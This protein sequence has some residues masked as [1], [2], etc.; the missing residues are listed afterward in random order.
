MKYRKLLAMCLLPLAFVAC[1]DDDAS[2][3][4]GEATI[5]FS[6]ATLEIKESIASINL[7]IVVTGTHD[8]LIKLSA[9]MTDSNGSNL[10]I[11]K[12]VIITTETLNMPV[13]TETVNL[14]VRLEGVTNDEIENGR[15]IVFEITNVEGATLGANA[16]CTV[17][18]VENNPLE[19]IY[20][21]GGVDA[22]GAGYLTA[23]LTQDVDDPTK[24]YLD[25]GTGGLLEV[26]LEE[27]EPLVRYNVT[28]PG[29]QVIGQTSYGDLYFALG[30]VNYNADTSAGFTGTW[31]N[32]VITLD[33]ELNTGIIFVDTT[34][35][36][37]LYVSALDA[38]GNVIPLTLTKQ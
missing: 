5:E 30:D 27:V 17:N 1:S 13:G 12:N 25:F 16:T 34:Y 15:Y 37:Y 26:H 22:A 6:Q 23:N 21:M 14:E 3:N 38:D 10:E 7:P 33:V 8:G 36:Y 11:D 20:L 24:A 2:Y 9:T 28:I 19:G 31:E 4:T 29:G 32:G 35:L 18:I